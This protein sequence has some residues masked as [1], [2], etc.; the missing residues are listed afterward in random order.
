MVELMYRSMSSLLRHQLKMSNQLQIPVALPP[1][2][3]RP[4]NIVL[5]AGWAP[6]PVWA[7]WSKENS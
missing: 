1:E 3:E 6:E 5:E 7:T 2:E 4:I